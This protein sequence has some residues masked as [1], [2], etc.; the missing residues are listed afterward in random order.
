MTH[1]IQCSPLFGDTF[2]AGR[3]L[4]GHARPFPTFCTVRDAE[5]TVIV[6]GANVGLGFEAAKHFASMNP[7][8][9]FLGCRSQQK[10]QATL[11][12]K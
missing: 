2:Q 6:V 8:R 10:G 5:K 12:G 1:R 4:K 7:N 3:A 11:E 9:L